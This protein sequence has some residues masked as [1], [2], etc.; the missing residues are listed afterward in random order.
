MSFERLTHVQFTP[1]VQ[2][3]NSKVKLYALGTVYCP[4]YWFEILIRILNQAKLFHI[5]IF[6][7]AS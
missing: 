7:E 5:I 2:W 4:Y 6:L 1:C 3:V